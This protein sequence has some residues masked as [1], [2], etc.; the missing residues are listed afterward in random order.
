MRDLAGTDHVQILKLT[1]P[2]PEVIAIE[3][4]VYVGMGRFPDQ[5]ECS[6]QG[7]NEG[8]DASELNHRGDA[9]L[10]GDVSGLTNAVGRTLVVLGCDFPGG[11]GRTIDALRSER[12]E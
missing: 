12:R 8:R 9:I 7:R 10:F 11:D 4:R 2:G 6:W 1:Q 3:H 5:L